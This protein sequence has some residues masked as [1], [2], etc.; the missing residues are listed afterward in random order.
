MTERTDIER[1]Q[2]VLKA[3]ATTSGLGGLIGLV[4][5]GFLSDWMGVDHVVLTAAVSAGLIVFAALVVHAS[6]TTERAVQLTPLISMGDVA[7]VAAT[8]VVVASGTLSTGG[9]V[10]AALIGLMVL[11]FACLQ[12]WFRTRATQGQVAVA[13]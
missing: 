3:N 12:L 11:D 13:A 6:S 8:V 2:L 10:L 9:N 1:L 4:A 5:A 7:W